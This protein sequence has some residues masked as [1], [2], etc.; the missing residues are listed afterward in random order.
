VRCRYAATKSRA[1]RDR[2]QEFPEEALPERRPAHIVRGQRR[3][4][5]GGQTSERP[6]DQECGRDERQPPA[7]HPDHGP[8]SANDLRVVE[9]ACNDWGGAQSACR[10]QPESKKLH[11]GFVRTD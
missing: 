9:V 3:H 8:G 6:D 10:H 7:D 1:V 4:E 2:E 11:R 5:C